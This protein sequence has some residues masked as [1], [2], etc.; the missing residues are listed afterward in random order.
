MALSEVLKGEPFGRGL[1]EPAVRWGRVFRRKNA[2]SSHFV[3]RNFIIR[4]LV[5]TV[6]RRW[7]IRS[8]KAYA[9]QKRSEVAVIPSLALRLVRMIFFFFLLLLLLFV[10]VF[11]LA[12]I[13]VFIINLL[14]FQ[15]SLAVRLRRWSCLLSNKS[16]I[17]GELPCADTTC[18]DSAADAMPLLGDEDLL[19]F[20]FANNV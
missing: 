17:D 18:C 14:G 13:V 8:P 7:G 16:I 2:F 6:S 20:L 10:V 19:R 15:S 4:R 9:A 3:I 5:A 1:A 12:L 11:H